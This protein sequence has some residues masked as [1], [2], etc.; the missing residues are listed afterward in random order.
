MIVVNKHYVV[1][2]DSRNYT[3]KYVQPKKDKD[4][5]TTEVKKTRGRK[6]KNKVDE[7]DESNE[8]YSVVGYYGSLEGA[9]KGILRDMNSRKLARGEM[10]LEKAISIIQKNTKEIEKLID[11]AVSGKK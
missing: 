3:A 5:E 9:L 8:Q 6:P 11:E 7:D 4:A 1:D 10:D 2:V